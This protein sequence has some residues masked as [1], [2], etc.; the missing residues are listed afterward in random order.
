LKGKTSRWRS[1]L[2]SGN[3]PRN[4]KNQQKTSEPLSAVRGKRIDVDE[5]PACPR[6]GG[7]PV[8]D[9]QGKKSRGEDKRKSQI[10]TRPNALGKN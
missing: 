6:P 10:T 4:K 1:K 9:I 2:A 3:Q 8:S 5:F 7:E